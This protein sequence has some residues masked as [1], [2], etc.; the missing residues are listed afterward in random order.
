MSET[1]PLLQIIRDRFEPEEQ[2]PEFADPA[3]TSGIAI[4][5][6][7]D[8]YKIT[9]YPRMEYGFEGFVINAQ[10]PEGL[11]GEAA[12]TRVETGFDNAGV[13][14]FAFTGE[15][16]VSEPNS[17]GVSLVTQSA[18]VLPDPKREGLVLP[19]DEGFE[20]FE[21]L[22]A[23][24]AALKEPVAEAM[25]T[26]GIDID[27]QTFHLYEPQ[28]HGAGYSYDNATNKR[29]KT[30]VTRKTRLRVG[31]T[32]G[33]TA[34]VDLDASLV[35]LEEDIVSGRVQPEEDPLMA[36]RSGTAWVRHANFQY[37]DSRAETSLPL[38]DMDSL[39]AFSGLYATI[40]TLYR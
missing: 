36:Y 25:G 1:A 38:L 10:A 7:P 24:L 37:P 34:H 6:T 23:R 28:K 18:V 40:R 4:D 30:T 12:P 22:Q 31:D 27:P 11:F 3:I 15:P 14:R 29:T 8:S 33:N 21:Q 26:L 35:Y 16:T 9:V 13:I 17:D 5:S 20:M 19:G 2:K 32:D 39:V